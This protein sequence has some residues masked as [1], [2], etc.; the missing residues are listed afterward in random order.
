VEQSKTEIRDRDGWTIVTPHGPVD[1]ATA[2]ELGQRLTE[3]QLR[4]DERDE[5]RVL[6]DL[7]DVAYLDSFGLAVLVEAVR[8]ARSRDARFVLRCSRDQLL[9]VL[10]R[11][12]L[13]A[14]FDVVTSIDDALG[15]R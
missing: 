6:V 13:D 14:T 7:D 2:P 12:G 8:R 11:S 4:D 5:P 9:D 10:A 3:L 15:R 1:V